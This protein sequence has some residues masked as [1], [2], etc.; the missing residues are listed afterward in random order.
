MGGASQATEWQ[1][2]ELMTEANKYA[3]PVYA[4][5]DLSSDLSQIREVVFIIHGTNRNGDDYFATMQSLLKASGKKSHEVLLL[6]PNFPA[7]QDKAKGFT[8]MPMW[9]ARGWSAGLDAKNTAF[10]LSAFNVMDALLL[11]FTSPDQLP[12]VTSVI[13][14]GHSAG[15]QFVQ[16]YAV[17]NPIDEQVRSRSLDLRY[18]VANPSS[19]LYF[20]TQRPN[21]KTFT[22]FQADNCPG[23][24]QYRYGLQDIIP[25]GA[26]KTSHELFKRYMYRNVVYL[27]GGNDQDPEHKYLDK[28]CSAQAQGSNRLA[29]AQAYI[30]YERFL[31]GRSTKI[32]HL[33]YEITGVGHNHIKM[34]G[35][36]CS[37]MIIFQRNAEK[38]TDAAT[39]QPYL[40]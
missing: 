35:S 21:A 31:A 13:I 36:A 5:H 3:F 38:S 14:A 10:G 8:D 18:I 4:N 9:N 1:R 27:M 26:G 15:A 37:M 24:N 33:A 39:C 29:R 6:A 20:T 28:S 19:F 2:L 22:D 12:N 23:F 17:L 32:N 34:F 16:R 25:Y 40:F 7:T 11:K 30:R